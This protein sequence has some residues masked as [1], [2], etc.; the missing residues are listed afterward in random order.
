M[1]GDLPTVRGGGSDLP[2]GVKFNVPMPNPVAA[3][4][5]PYSTSS[6]TPSTSAFSS[7]SSTSSLPASPSNALSSLASDAEA[8][9]FAGMVRSTPKRPAMQAVPRAL[10]VQQ[11]LKPPPSRPQSR[12]HQISPSLN[13]STS[14]VA[15][16]SD[17]AHLTSA[18]S[19]SSL[20]HSSPTQ[21][22]DTSLEVYQYSVPSPPHV[23][24]CSFL[25]SNFLR[26]PSI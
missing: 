9:P 17:A 26:P 14:S 1:Y 8:D 15:A 5:T 4:A 11:Q 10:R 13:T 16:P 19:P 23:C 3:P 12:Q 20:R 6:A 2:E 24:P 18:V 22:T 7:S 21:G 25:S